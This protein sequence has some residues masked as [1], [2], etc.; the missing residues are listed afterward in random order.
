MVTASVRL[1]ITFN[2]GKV[3][4]V[5]TTYSDAA[6]AMVST[7][8]NSTADYTI[9]GDVT[10]DGSVAGITSGTKIDTTDTTPGSLGEKEFDIFAISNLTTLYI[11]NSDGLNDG[12]TADKRPTQLD[13]EIVFTRQ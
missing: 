10:I 11:G 12:T 5:G 9:D 6:C 7:V 3:S 2:D 1:D 8:E 13:S 4:A